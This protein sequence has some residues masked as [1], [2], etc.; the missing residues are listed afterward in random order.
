MGA[1][2][3]R[4][5]ARTSTYVVALIL[6]VVM[7]FPF[8]WM[9]SA[10]FKP[11][12]DVFAYPIQWIPK[13]FQP[14]NYSELWTTI[15]FPL[16]YLNSIKV[17]VAVTLGQLITCSLAGYAFARLSFPGKNKLFIIYLAAFM[18]PYQVIMIP[19][20]MVVRSLGLVDSHWSLI[21]LESFSAYGVFLMRQFFT[22]ISMELSEAARID[23]S[24]EFGIFARIILPL[25]KPGLATLGIFVFASVWND[26]QAPLI[27]IFSDKLKTLPLGLASLNGEFTSETQLIMAGAVL[28]LIP[29]VAVFLFLQRYFVSGLTVGAVKG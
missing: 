21:L 6:S 11:Q 9:V 3:S 20:Y 10:S 14:E 5:L 26:F 15:P 19:Q 13:V 7:I 27:Y 24:S 25:A 1:L 28:S 8:V 2:L 22:G 12:E 16:Y 4:G 29:I 18:I 23:G 17:S